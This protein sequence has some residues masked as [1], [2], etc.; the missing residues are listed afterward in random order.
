MLRSCSG[1]DRT[2]RDCGAWPRAARGT[3]SKKSYSALRL[4]L[5]GLRALG[6]GRRRRPQ[7]PKPSATSHQ[8]IRPQP[9]HGHRAASVLGRQTTASVPDVRSKAANELDLRR[10]VDGV[11]TG[12]PRWT[13]TMPAISAS[14]LAGSASITRCADQ[15]IKRSDD[16]VPNRPWAASE[17]PPARW[18]VRC[19]VSARPLAVASNPRPYPAICS[20]VRRCVADPNV[21]PITRVPEPRRAT[22]P[23]AGTE[24]FAR[25]PT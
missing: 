10:F 18:H 5:G 14:V 1:E 16:D 6:P 21:R 25:C 7:R 13:T 23:N 15:H 19:L 12:A 17:I 24:A 22:S 2:T 20:T 3:T 11:G 4:R 9:R 8:R